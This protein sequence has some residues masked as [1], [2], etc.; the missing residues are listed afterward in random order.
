VNRPGQQNG[1]YSVK[2]LGGSAENPLP[3]ARVESIE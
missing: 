1:I 2:G 3:I